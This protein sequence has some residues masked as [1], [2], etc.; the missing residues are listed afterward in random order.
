MNAGKL[1]K[2]ELSAQVDELYGRLQT[3]TDKL[4]AAENA[5]DE[6]PMKLASAQYERAEFRRQRDEAQQAL[7]QLTGAMP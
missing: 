7:A 2:A 6:A 4:R 1:T 3:T 5:R